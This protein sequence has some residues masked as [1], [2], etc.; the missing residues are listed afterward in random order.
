VQS[1][2]SDTLVDP[3][4]PAVG[5]MPSTKNTV[6]VE[7]QCFLLFFEKVYVFK[8]VIS[9]NSLY[10]TCLKMVEMHKKHGVWDLTL[11]IV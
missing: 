2:D 4:S 1:A 10:L 5:F 6:F 8:I 3:L 11:R 9:G 7:K